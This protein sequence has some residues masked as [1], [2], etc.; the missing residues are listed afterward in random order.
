MGKGSKWRKH[1]DFKKYYTNMVLISGES[2]KTNPKKI[3]KKHG[4]TRYVYK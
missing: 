4:K 2:I 1:F 3:I